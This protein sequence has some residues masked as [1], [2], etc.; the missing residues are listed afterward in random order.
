[1]AEK[2]DPYVVLGVDKNASSDDIKSAYRKL[3]RKYHP[4][5]NKEEGA[6]AKFKEVQEAY[7]ILSDPDKKA[8]YDQFGYAAFDQQGGFGGGG[9]GDFGDIDLGD[10]FGSFFGGGG[11]RAQRSSGPARGNDVLRRVKISFMDSINGK[12]IDLNLNLDENCPHCNGT[13]AENPSDVTTCQECRGSGF[14]TAVQQTLFGRMQT[15]RECPRCGGTGKVVTNKCKTCNGAGY[16]TVNKTIE[17]KIPAGIASG[18]Q[19]CVRG[20]GERGERGGPN[21]DLY[22]EV[23]VEASKTF[24][25]EGNSIHINQDISYL[26]A[27][28]GASIEVE[29]VYGPVTLDIPAGTQPNAILRLRG[30][31]VK[32]LRTGNVGDQYIHF[33]VII[34]TSI[35]KE[36]RELL[37]K[38]ASATDARYKKKGKESIFDRIKKTF[39]KN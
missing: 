13:G 24:T 28:L 37:E 2:R 21:G 19:I 31:G 5:L 15:Q 4:D 32:D 36:E 11:R 9:F 3:A 27:I 16:K 23:I 1:M 20:K 30:K 18:Q 22:I 6:E 8:K 7:E 39:T 38:L 14:I 10:I 17:V 29:T 26:E 25:R 34:P 33:N 35:N 12:T